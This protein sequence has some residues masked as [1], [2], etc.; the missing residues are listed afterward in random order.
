M[1]K[2]STAGFDMTK[3][4]IGDRLFNRDGYYV[5]LVKILKD[6]DWPYLLNIEE[7]VS[8]NGFCFDANNPFGDD[9]IGFA[10]RPDIVIEYTSEEGS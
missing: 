5:T 8:V 9:I 2:Y 6:S 4:K 10:D 7:T 3:V 1:K